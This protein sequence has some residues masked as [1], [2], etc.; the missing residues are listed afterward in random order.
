[1]YNRKEVLENEK[2]SKTKRKICYD[3]KCTRKCY[4]GKHCLIYNTF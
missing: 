1:M 3:K 2:Y 4:A